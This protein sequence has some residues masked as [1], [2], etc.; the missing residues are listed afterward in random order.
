MATTVP[1]NSKL[2]NEDIAPR[3]E[4]GHWKAWD[5][6]AWWMS[7]WH[8][9]GGYAMAVGLIVLG[10]SGW[11]MAVGLIVGLVIIYLFSNLMGAAGQKVGVPFPVFARISFGVYGANI[12]AILRAIVAVA[13][14]GIQTYLASA[15]V[16]L[17]IVKVFPSAKGMT[18]ASFLGLSGLGWL[19]FLV[20]W[21]AQLAVLWRGMEAVRKLSDFAGT[22][23]WVAMIALAVWV[24]NRAHWSLNWNYREAVSNAPGG[25][26]VALLG[27]IFI[28]TAYMGGP[29]LNFAD[30]TRLA[31][32]ARDVRRGNQLGLLLNGV[33][34]GVVSVVIA[35]ASVKVYGKAVTD[36]LQMLADMDS[37][38]ML[39]VAIISVA[40]ATVG[41]NIILNFVSPAYDFAN[42]A[43]K[44]IS[45]RTGG[46]ITAVLALLVMPWKL[47]SNPIA[48]NYFIG[49]VG[50][51]MG[52]LLGITLVDYY[53]VRRGVV[54]VAALYS[55]DPN[56]PY[57]YRKGFNRKAIVSLVIAGVAALAAAYVPA[58][59]VLA[60]F[61]WPIGVLLGGVS[62][63]L[64]NGAERAA[65]APRPAPAVVASGES[66]AS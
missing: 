9:L 2:Y 37:V 29:M 6:F 50:A 24:L 15:A 3:S 1:Q 61:S 66:V 33:A 64:L 4:A 53:L 36:P 25:T 39:L 55:D 54:D 5:L 42:A 23:I 46:V 10:I 20:L 26:F 19:C 52:P 48:V 62:Y 58:L 8:S 40:I 63:Y 31:P 27:A 57:F 32:N 34:F 60:H 44:Y 65:L 45:F 47:Y 30:F 51:T 56:G 12:P 17:L 28:T 13:W 14:Y 21:A 38:A 18:T 22:T 7:A 49:G 16:M 41:I 43:P 11:Q 35:L 59:S